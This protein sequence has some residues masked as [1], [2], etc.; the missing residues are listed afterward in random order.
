MASNNVL[1]DWEMS[2]DP[3][4]RFF[5]SSIKYPPS[6]LVLEGL[7]NNGLVSK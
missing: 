3:L 1:S 4:E 2:Y 7:T 6:S 5:Y